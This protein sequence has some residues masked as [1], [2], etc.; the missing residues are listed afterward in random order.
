MDF[1]CKPSKNKPCLRLQSAFTE[2][3][4]NP[5][6]S[7]QA[8]LIFTFGRCTPYPC[9]PQHTAFL[10]ESDFDFRSLGLKTSLK[11]GGSPKVV[12]L[13]PPKP[14]NPKTVNPKAL[15]SEDDR[16]RLLSPLIESVPVALNH[17]VMEPCKS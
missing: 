6:P 5:Q 4:L 9:Q 15:N 11:K 13:Q 2:P 1:V 14:L 8:P 3:H 17:G 7:Q 12:R 10:A 16:H